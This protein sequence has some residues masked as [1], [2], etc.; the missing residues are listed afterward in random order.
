M[1]IQT[2]ISGIVVY[3]AS[4]L[5]NYT[6]TIERCKYE[7]KKILGYNQSLDFD[8]EVLPPQKMKYKQAINPIISQW[9]NKAIY[10]NISFTQY[11]EAE[12]YFTD[13]ETVRLYNKLCPV[14][15]YSYN[16]Y[17]YITEMDLYNKQIIE[18]ANLVSDNSL[19]LFTFMQI[20]SVIT[21][22]SGK[23]TKLKIESFKKS[24]DYNRT[25]NVVGDVSSKKTFDNMFF[26]GKEEFIST[27]NK[28]SKG[29]LTSDRCLADNK[30][31]RLLYGEKGAGKTSLISAI[32]NYLQRSVLLYDMSTVNRKESFIKAVQYCIE[33]KRI[34]V[35]EEFD[36]ILKVIQS[37][38][39]AKAYDLMD[40]LCTKLSDAKNAVEIKKIEGLIQ[41]YEP[42]TIIT[43]DVL[44]TEIDGIKSTDGLVI[45]AT[46]NHPE[47]IDDALKREYRLEPFE[48]KKFN[49]TLA[50]QLIRHLYYLDDVDCIDIKDN[51]LISPAKLSK[52]CMTYESH[53]DVI[54][55]L[56]TYID[57]VS[58]IDNTTNTVDTVD[59]VDT[60]NIDNTD[61]TK[62]INNT[63]D[64]VDIVNID[65]T[66]NTKDI[67]NTKDIVDIVDI[68]NTDNTKDINNTK[69]IVD[70]VDI[71]DSKDTND[72]K[73]DEGTASTD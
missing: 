57:N 5:V 42:S 73:Y 23:K 32:A 25:A 11:A 6:D 40:T 68:D 62:D 39:S 7:V 66:D 45:I 70:I 48:C 51:L 34:L 71:V 14:Y 54:K 47:Q 20:A 46:T 63:K 44:L 19:A 36:C 29:L 8:L 15:R 67:N 49:S 43:L 30:Y 28:F 3:I 56:E 33:N 26:E 9:L 17:V 72:N 41:D 31:C 4:L 16:S 53:T 61:N 10:N 69:D 38:K 52:L 60:V 50:K 37:R 35:L 59:T 55:Y 22:K 2:I 58:D 64:I 12:G 1:I 21:K 18:T 13:S 65:N 24:G 27:L